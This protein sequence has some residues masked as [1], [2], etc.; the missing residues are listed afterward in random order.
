MTMSHELQI[1]KKK[2]KPTQQEKQVSLFDFAY[3]KFNVYFL[4]YEYE[5]F[6]RNFFA[7]VNLTVFMK[8]GW[9][10]EDAM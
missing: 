6:S 10:G 4:K 7:V 9:I 5:L 8:N 2:K 1:F 3:I